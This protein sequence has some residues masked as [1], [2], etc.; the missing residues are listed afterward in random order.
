MPVCFSQVNRFVYLFVFL[1]GQVGAQGID[2]L[3]HALAKS[4][5]DTNRVNILNELSY[6]HWDVAPLK[7]EAYAKSALR[8]ADSLKYAKGVY[9]AHSRLGT[10]YFSRGNFQMALKEYVSSRQLAQ[11]A[12]DENAI[13]STEFNMALV[14]K[15]LGNNDLALKKYKTIAAN[16]LKTS[17]YQSLAETY[18]NIADL[19]RQ[20]NKYDSSIFYAK[21]ALELLKY[22]ENNY[23][24]KYLYINIGSYYYQRREFYSG[25]RYC[26][27]AI[28]LYEKSDN[29][30][31]LL[32]S[33]ELM[34]E[35][36]IKLGRYGEAKEILSKGLKLSKGYNI[37]SSE[38][39]LYKIFAQLDSAKG[40]FKEALRFYKKYATLN[41][42]L[43]NFDQRK[44]LSELYVINETIEKEKEN[45]LLKQDKEI[46]KRELALSK[47]QNKFAIAIISAVVVGLLISIVA[48]IALLRSMS[49]KHKAYVQVSMLNEELNLQKQKLT[50]ANEEIRSMNENLEA[51]VKSRTEKIEFQKQQLSEFAFF[52]AHKVRGPL[53]RII[54]LIFICSGSKMPCQQTS[55]PNAWRQCPQKWTT[56][57]HKLT[58]CSKT[59]RYSTANDWFLPA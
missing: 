24:T 41:D 23:L 50:A 52:N 38:A 42:S 39:V 31:G 14:Y 26:A 33:Y 21:S 47:E 34:A 27:K 12:N 40:N 2:S 44:E 5:P 7:G 17:N 59:K 22:D 16:E 57:L 1:C 15:S 35:L 37:R 9:T 48:V 6:L 49:A 4:R 58:N 19:F 11:L 3:T 29:V 18:N 13:W 51:I 30:K 20:M 55:W 56:C 53:A 25:L 10:N 28:Q 32:D 45:E 54:G 46:Q 36:K 8:L 43:I